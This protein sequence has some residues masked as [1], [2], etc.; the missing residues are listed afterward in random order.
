MRQMSRIEVR[1]VDRRAIEDY[2]LPGI[3][4]ME[5]AGRNAALLLDS[6]QIAGPIHL[7]CGKGNNGGDAYVMARHLENRGHTLRVLLA[8]RPEEITG[9]ARIHFEVIQRAGITIVDLSQASREDWERELKSAAWIVDALL[10]TGLSGTVRPPYVGVIEA[11]NRSGQRVFAVDLPSGMDCDTGQPLGT[12][13]RATLTGTFVAHKQGFSAPGANLWTGK[14]HVLDIGVPR[15]LLVA[16][17]SAGDA[18]GN[19]Q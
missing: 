8:C 1:D 16:I 15:A 11:I 12:C 13:V 3:V 9:D 2:G 10:G 4:L 18:R 19:L 14:V 5:N 6:Q 7:V 17:E